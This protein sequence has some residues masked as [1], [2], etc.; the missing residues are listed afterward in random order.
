MKL[1]TTRQIAKALSLNKKSVFQKAAYEKWQYVVRGNR[2][3]WVESSLP[4]EVKKA[5]RVARFLQ[6]N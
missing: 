3:L 6:R 5:V 4:L 1:L 2:Y